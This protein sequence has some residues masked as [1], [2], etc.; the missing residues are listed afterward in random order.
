MDFGF[1]DYLAAAALVATALNAL[2]TKRQSDSAKTASINDYRAKLSDQHA[3][4]RE[5][6]REVRKRH[7]E[8][9]RRLSRQ[10]GDT[11]TTIIHRFDEYDVEGHV[12]RYLRHLLHEC[13]EMVFY[14][15]RG[16]LAWQTGLNISHR[17]YQVVN[18][19][20]RLNPCADH[21]GDGDS[22]HAFERRYLADPN[23]YM[24][25]DLLADRY[26]C[27]LVSELKSR[28]DPADGVSLLVGLQ[29]DLAAF[30]ADYESLLPSVRE[31]V[32]Q[33]EELIEEGAAEH[34]PLTESPR[35]HAA[36][37]REKAVLD[38]LSYLKIP[39]IEKDSAR[40]Y[41]NFISQSIY[42]CAVL[43]AI[44]GI[45]SWGWYRE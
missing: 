35:L 20:N 16:Q 28:I 18:V 37:T 2:Y 45:H 42:A 19:E 8:E 3:R 6:F 40:H 39:V 5:A 4:Y 26:F 25:Q 38:A 17:F 22:Q 31:S 14:A 30:R 21:F 23:S 41:V 36:L 27:S 44:Q 7:K 11:L 13:S 15:F 32:E 9:I 29:D 24:E 43:H 33:L 12:P 1:S 34:F 10:A